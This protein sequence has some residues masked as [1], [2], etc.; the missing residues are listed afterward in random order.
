MTD[1]LAAVD[2]TD[3]TDLIHEA[4]MVLGTQSA[5]GSSSFGPFTAGYNAS[6]TFS[7]GS[8]TLS[9]PNVVHLTNCTLAYSL[10]FSFGIDLNKVIPPLCFPQVCIPIPFD[11]QICT[12]AFCIT[13]PS[14]TVPV[15][16]SDTLTFSA[17]FGVTV[18][19]SSSDWL[20]NFVVIGIPSLNLSATATGLLAAIGAAVTAIVSAVPLIGP[21]LAL[22]IGAIMALITIAALTGWLGALLTPFVSG[23]TLTRPVPKQIQVSTTPAVT[24]SIN[25][26]TAD[27]QVTD[28]NEL[29][30]SADI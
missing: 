6:A 5:S 22:A 15:S 21:F 27:V 14:I 20:V 11:G 25:S 23:L 3:A 24:V 26:L 29:V 9:A 4:E 16:Y 10:K 1:I 28:K 19:S 2:E 13:W 18:A 7:G 12:P 17:D 30:V 8:V